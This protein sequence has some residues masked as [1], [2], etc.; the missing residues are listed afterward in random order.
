MHFVISILTCTWFRAQVIINQTLC[1]LHWGVL[2][3]HSG[4]VVVAKQV[5][6][7]S[8]VKQI[9]TVP[10]TRFTIEVVAIKKNLNLF[11]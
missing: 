2:L 4:K 5:L 1:L 9:F 7:R 11:Q 8:T 3:L 10:T 6:K